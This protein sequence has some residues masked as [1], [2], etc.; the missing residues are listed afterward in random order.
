[1]VPSQI[2]TLRADLVPVLP[3]LDLEPLLLLGQ[4]LDLQLRLVEP[5]VKLFQLGQH[6]VGFLLLLGPA[7]VLHAPELPQLGQLRLD[8]LQVPVELESVKLDLLLL[9][10]GLVV[11]RI[12]N[13]NL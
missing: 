3:G 11:L 9:G 13:E 8:L 2:W 6:P 7:D 10:L 5:L 12:K 4:V 1:M